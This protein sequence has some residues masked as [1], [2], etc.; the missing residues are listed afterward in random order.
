MSESRK[1][2]LFDRYNK[3]MDLPLDVRTEEWVLRVA[4]KEELTYTPLEN[5][6]WVNNFSLTKQAMSR[7]QDLSRA[8]QERLYAANPIL[9]AYGKPTPQ[10][11][12]AKRSGRLHPGCGPSENWG[13]VQA[14][15]PSE[16]PR[17]RWGGL[18]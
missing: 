6:N 5:G 11:E 17:L 3:L 12:F 14:R 8:A 15:Q 13:C 18:G 16:G 9:M 2:F 7:Y 1:D 10:L 4:D